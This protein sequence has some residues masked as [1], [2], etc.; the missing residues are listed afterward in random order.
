MEY[1]KIRT[2]V[3]LVFCLSI[4]VTVSVAIIPWLAN[5]PVLTKRLLQ[6]RSFME[7]F[8][9]RRCNMGLGGNACKCNGFHFAGKRNSLE[10]TSS[11]SESFVDADLYEMIEKLENLVTEHG[12]ADTSFQTLK[13]ST[14]SLKSQVPD[15][16]DEK[17]R[18]SR[19]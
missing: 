16:Y 13:D 6:R 3:L 9:A 11:S 1:L 14:E 5:D 19:M 15:M 10:S 12:N 4:S 18:K 17:D 7:G 8:C 2:S